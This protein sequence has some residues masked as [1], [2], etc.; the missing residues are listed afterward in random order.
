LSYYVA[1]NLAL[2]PPTVT[3]PR[4]RNIG[5]DRYRERTRGES[6]GRERSF[7]VLLLSHAEALHSFACYLTRDAARAEDLVQEA[8][9]RALGAEARFVA[10]SNAKSWLFRILHNIFLDCERRRRKNPVQLREASDGDGDDADTDSSS[11]VWLRGD[12]E[13]DRV[14]ALVVSDIESALAR[15]S[16]EAR[17]V[18]LL[19]LEGL[20]ET[21]IAKVMDTPVG[22]VK[23]RLGRARATLREELQEYSK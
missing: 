21:E 5:S 1:F 7:G 8:F 9:A 17:S 12:L 20:T 2:R 11:D 18:V 22:T 19:D 3:R 4:P 16:I 23:S 13:I 15:L 10:G 14:R 6:L